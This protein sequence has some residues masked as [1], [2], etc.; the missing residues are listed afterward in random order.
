M[1]WFCCWHFS[2]V[3]VENWIFHSF[4]LKQSSSSLAFP[5]HDIS[6]FLCVGVSLQLHTYPKSFLFL[7]PLHCCY[8]SLQRISCIE[9]T[10]LG[11]VLT[12]FVLV[13]QKWCVSS[14]SLS[15]ISIGTA[16]SRCWLEFCEMLLHNMG[17]AKVASCTNRSIDLLLLVLPPFSL[18]DWWIFEAAIDWWELKYA[19]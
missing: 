6:L 1:V 4:C 18:K 12:S 14:F 15:F 2:S 17:I 13:F 19:I 16:I 3:S 9:C 11:I 5:L 10:L 7:S 8:L